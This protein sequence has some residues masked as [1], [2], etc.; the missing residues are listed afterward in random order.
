MNDIRSC[1]S[2]CRDEKASWTQ[3]SWNDFYRRL[4]NELTD[5]EFTGNSDQYGD[6]IFSWNSIPLNDT[7]GV[8][9]SLQLAVRPCTS[10][11]NL[12]FRIKAHDEGEETQEQLRQKLHQKLIRV[13]NQ[14]VR[15]PNQ[16]NNDDM[17]AAIW[18]KEW[19][20]FDGNSKFNFD[21]TVKN[22]RCAASVLKEACENW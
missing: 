2:W 22:L 8:E 17:T 7:H 10:I 1:L 4:Q 15:R 9:A 13:N 14:F 18:P 12:H 20:A 21:E 3:E 19:L 11:T 6:L 16:S 5:G